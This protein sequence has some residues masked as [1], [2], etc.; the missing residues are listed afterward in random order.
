M[1]II[2]SSKITIVKGGKSIELE[3]KKDEKGQQMANLINEIKSGFKLKKVD[4]SNSPKPQPSG[5]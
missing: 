2:D 3:N 5:I 1:K 4:V